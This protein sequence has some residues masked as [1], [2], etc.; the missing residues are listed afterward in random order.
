[1]LVVMS[2]LYHTHQTEHFTHQVT[3]VV[4]VDQVQQEMRDQ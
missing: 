4:L 1:V 3:Q 2:P